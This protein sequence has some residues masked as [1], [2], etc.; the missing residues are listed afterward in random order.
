LRR[1]L[2]DRAGPAG[3]P[4]AVVHLW[5]LDLPALEATERRYLEAHSTTG[6]YSLIALAQALRSD[7][8]QSAAPA[9]LHIVTRGAQAADRGQSVEPLGALAWGVGR[10][11]RHQELTAHRGKLIDLAPNARGGPRPDE[12][13]R[14]EARALLDDILHN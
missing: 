14:A 7:P 5:N 12:V 6:A 4:D 2:A 11:L 9:A 3:V 10:V 8:D 1:L 13:R